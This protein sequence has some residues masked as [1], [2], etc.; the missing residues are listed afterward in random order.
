MLQASCH[1]NPSGH[2]A[3]NKQVVTQDY[4]LTLGKFLSNFFLP[5]P[6][7]LILIITTGLPGYQSSHHCMQLLL[8]FPYSPSETGA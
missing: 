2:H 5:V 7:A 3:T 6:R 4:S 8:T 1:S